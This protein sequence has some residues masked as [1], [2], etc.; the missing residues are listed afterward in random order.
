M[1][2]TVL[3]LLFENKQSLKY[4]R[5]NNLF[6]DNNPIDVR[7][8]IR[9]IVKADFVEMR[10]ANYEMLGN[11][12]PTIGLDSIELKAK[13]KPAGEQFYLNTYM[14][15]NETNT[16]NVDQFVNVS[17]DNNA[18]I[19][20]TKDHS[21]SS[22]KKE[23]IKPIKQPPKTL[24]QTLWSNKNMKKVSLT[25]IGGLILYATIELIK[26]YFFN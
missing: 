11:G 24:M 19:L 6:I 2:E 23:E 3:K 22:I 15:K 17:G 18:P 9:K 5:I 25:V 21:S 20:Q 1:T 10:D 14:K 16:F 12:N 4:I 7:S 13:I 26:Y 8:F